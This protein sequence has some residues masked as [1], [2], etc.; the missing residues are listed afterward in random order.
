MNDEPK[1]DDVILTDEEGNLI[2]KRSDLKSTKRSDLADSAE[3]V[4]EEGNPKSEIE[5]LKEKL[6]VALEDKQK[7]LDSWQRDKAEFLNARK[8]D[9]QAQEEFIKFAKEDVIAEMLPVLASFEMAFANKDAWEKADKNWRVGV[10]YIYSQLKQ[11]LESHGLKEINPIGLPFDPMR[12][13]ALEYTPVE[14]ESDS[15]KVMVVV[16]KGYELAGKAIRAPKVKV[17]EFKKPV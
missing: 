5:K 2:G 12:D 11:I 1:N 17:G 13:E 15:N 4:D 10:E 16:S 6:K 3:I 14:N 7:Y 9:K 8:R